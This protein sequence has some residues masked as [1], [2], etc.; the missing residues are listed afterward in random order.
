MTQTLVLN[1]ATI[2]AQHSTNTQIVANV[3]ECEWS[4]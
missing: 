4:F 3:R 1:I 2:H